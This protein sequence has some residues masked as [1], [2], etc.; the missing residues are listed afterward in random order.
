MRTKKGFTLIELI[1]VIAIMGILVGVLVPSWGY[2]MQRSRTRTQNNKAK[3]IFNAAQT[4][5][6]DLNFSERRYI[7]VYTDS[8][9]TAKEMETALG[10]MYSNIPG[11]DATTEWYYYWDGYK[12]YRCDADGNKLTADNAGYTAVQF[13]SLAI[14]EWDEKIGNAIKK[15]VDDDMVYKFYVKDYKIMSVAS[16]RFADDRYIGSY[17]ITVD[18]VEEYGKYKASDIRDTKVKGLDMKY[19]D[20]VDTSDIT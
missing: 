10:H 5:V 20:I 14:D 15:I 11:V 3:A 8:T 18:K 4:V 16:S 9:S 19:F 1:I 2:Y 12:G 6:T 7:A 17:P 13:G